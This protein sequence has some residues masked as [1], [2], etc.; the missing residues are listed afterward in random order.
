MVRSPG[1][2]PGP[3]I[4]CCGVQDEI[5]QKAKAIKVRWKWEMVPTWPEPK[6][7]KAHWDH[8]LEE[9]TWLAKA[10]CQER[11][12][13]LKVRPLAV[14]PPRAVSFLFSF[15][16]FLFLLSNCVVPLTQPNPTQPNPKIEQRLPQEMPISFCTMDS[17]DGIVRSCEGRR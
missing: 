7:H 15:F 11:K 13:K 6:R 4:G 2:R 8:L 12:H 3:D 14:Q 9:M 5:L 1:S 16:S 17:D 10:V